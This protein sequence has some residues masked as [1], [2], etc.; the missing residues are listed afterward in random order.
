MKKKITT[1]LLLFLTI[2]IVNAQKFDVETL[3]FSGNNDKYL[4]ILVL[5]DGY[6]AEEQTKFIKTSKKEIDYL[7]SAEGKQVT[8][9]KNLLILQKMLEN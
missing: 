4:N 9:N 3:K 7:Y 5:G 8:N 1:L 6:T 2:N